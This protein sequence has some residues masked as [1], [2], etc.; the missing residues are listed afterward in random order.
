VF[1]NGIEWLGNPRSIALRQ[2]QEIVVAYGTYVS[3]P[4]P[5]PPFFPFPNGL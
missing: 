2:H 1:V 5:I 3:I 4:K